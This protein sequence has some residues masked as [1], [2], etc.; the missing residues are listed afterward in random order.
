MLRDR[1]LV[2]FPGGSEGEGSSVV[3][4]VALIAAVAQVRSLAR[5][6]PQVRSSSGG[7]DSLFWVGYVVTPYHSVFCSN[8]TSGDMVV[9]ESYVI[10]LIVV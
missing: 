6:P 8:F 10:C 1:L 2:E 9:W 4:S 7:P 5:E 3:P